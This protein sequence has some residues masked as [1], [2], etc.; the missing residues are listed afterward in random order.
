M[1]N[2]TAAHGEAVGFWLHKQGGVMR[3]QV[4][5]PTMEEETTPMMRFLYAVGVVMLMSG[6]AMTGSSKAAIPGIAVLLFC[7]LF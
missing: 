1:T 3:N 2:N 5:A 6:P 7:S 4:I